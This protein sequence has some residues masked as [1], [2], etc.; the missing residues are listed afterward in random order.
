MCFALLM[1]SAC[2]NDK[3]KNAQVGEAGEVAETATNAKMISITPADC[4]VLWTGT[5]PTGSHTGYIMAKSGEIGV[6]SGKITSGRI[7]LDMNSITNTDLEGDNKLGL[8]S[9]LKGTGTDGVDDFFNVNKYPTAEFVM[10]K[11]TEIKN[12]PKANSLIYGNLTMKD[13]T[14]Q[15]GIKANVMVNDKGVKV[16]SDEFSINRTD[17]GIKYKSKNFIEGLKDKFIDDEIKLT[18]ALN[19]IK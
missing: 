12:D 16:T 19:T 17:W 14:K 10:T 18:I 6:E 7:V 15:I 3:S 2:K 8:E 5:K 13:I 4:K 11:I 9:H 1:L